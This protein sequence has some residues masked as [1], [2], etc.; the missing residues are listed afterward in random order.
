MKHVI[1]YVKRYTPHIYFDENEPFYPRQIGYTI[2]KETSKSPSF[3]RIIEIGK[4][5]VACV[6]E[7]AIYWNYDITHLYDLEHYWVFIGENGE[8]LDAQGSFHGKCITILMKDRS[9]II[10][11]T[12]VKIYSQPGKHAFAPLP[13]FFDYIPGVEQS[14]YEDAGADGLTVTEI[15]ARGRYE[16]TPEM[17]KSIRQYM[18]R[19]KFRPTH[20]YT[21]Y[22]DIAEDQLVE[23]KELDQNIPGF[24]E[25]ELRKIKRKSL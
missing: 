4:N 25:E 5:G 12:H 13:M 14:T 16:T 10:D 1:E 19:Y 18:E 8:I 6:I 24:I 3:N 23:W 7:Y 17:N 21:N 9:N 2:F 22:Y 11:N 20:Q 15:V